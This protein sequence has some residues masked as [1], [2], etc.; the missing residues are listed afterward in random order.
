MSVLKTQKIN[1]ITQVFQGIL[2][3]IVG[4][5]PLGNRPC[6]NDSKWSP[7]EEKTGK[8]TKVR[9]IHAVSR[10]RLL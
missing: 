2:S 3:T 8:P 7:I 6:R 1:A 4:P 9:S 5:M 10:Y